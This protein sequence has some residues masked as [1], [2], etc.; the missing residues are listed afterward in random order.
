M[1]VGVALAYSAG[2]GSYSMNDSKGEVESTLTGAYPYLRYRPGGRLSLWGV[3]GLGEGELRLT[4][5]GGEEMEA[6][7]STRMA[8]AGARGE[9]LTVAGYALAIKTDVLLVR[10]ESDAVSGP[11]RC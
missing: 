10:T 1:L 3:A 11:R 5:A 7:L 6:D 8:A 4:P 2:D 9:L